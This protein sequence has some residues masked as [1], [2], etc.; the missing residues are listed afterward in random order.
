MQA[1]EPRRLLA[2]VVSTLGQ[3]GTL[4][5]T[6]SGDADSIGITLRDSLLRVRGNGIL[7]TFAASAVRRIE[8]LADAGNDVVDWSG[9]SIP[10]YI[11][12]GT[13]NDSVT[14]GGGSD[15]LSGAAG[16]DTLKGGAGDDRLSGGASIDQV[17]G[18]DGADRIYGGVHNDYLDG[19]AGV[20]RLWGEAGNDQLLGGASSDK[21]YAGPGDDTLYGSSGTDL[22]SGEAGNDL[23][24]ARDGVG[25][26]VDGGD[27]FDRAH[28]DAIDTQ[29]GV[30]TAVAL[31]TARNALSIARPSETIEL[32]WTQVAQELPGASADRIQVRE[33]GTPLVSQAIDL[34]RDGTPEQLIFQADFAARKSRTFEIS[35]ASAPVTPPP[36]KVMA[37]Y[38][39]ERSDDFAW[40]ND[41]VGFRV[42]GPALESVDPAGSGIDA[43]QKR[44][45]AL[46]LN[47][48]YDAYVNDGVSYHID[49][50]EGLDGYKVG[51]TR[52]AGAPAVWKNGTLYDSGTKG[53]RTWKILAEGPIRVVFELGYESFNAGGENVTETRRITLDAGWNLNRIEST[54]TS[55]KLGSQLQFAV[56]LAKHAPKPGQAAV[57]KDQG[58]IRYWDAADSVEQPPVDNGNIG[59]GAVI[60]P[61]LVVDTAQTTDHVLLIAKPQTGKPLTYWSGQGWDKSGDFTNVAAWDAHLQQASQRVQSP[62]RVSV[63][64]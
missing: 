13:G 19:G 23:L 42:Y 15:T 24:S 22:L 31:F 28:A 21:L 56:G 55:D 7:K 57:H 12:A 38:V 59:T 48:W 16:K 3:N 11:D 35:V 25:E 32:S 63:T 9:I 43:W 52:G 10:T 46:V 49:H 50:G 44:T 20:D 40:E 4:R 58:W 39:P 51:R 45:R 33:S 60:D 2:A 53:W 8:I 5:V 47:D 6:G 37:R 14:A 41:R 26:I 36:S 17:F 29:A 62:L 30:E 61:S 1:L 18:E 64:R 34:N 54:F 27:G